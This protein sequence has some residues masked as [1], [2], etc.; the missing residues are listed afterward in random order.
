VDR[1]AKPDLTR[2]LPAFCDFSAIAGQPPQVS[3]VPWHGSGDLVALAHSNCFLVVPEG[4]HNP[5]PGS[6]VRILLP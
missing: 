5:E 6:L 4:S 3:F 1:H 2:F